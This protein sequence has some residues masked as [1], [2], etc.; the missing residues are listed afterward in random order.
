MI[1]VTVIIMLLVSTTTIAAGKY[2]TTNYPEDRKAI[3]SLEK[4]NDRTIY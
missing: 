2:N 1:M 3:E 4:I